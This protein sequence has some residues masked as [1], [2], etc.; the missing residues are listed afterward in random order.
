MNCENVQDLLIDGGEADASLRRDALEHLSECRDCRDA[1][2][3]VAALHGSRLQRIPPPTPGAMERALA[4]AV[5]GPASAGAARQKRRAPGAAGRAGFWSGVAVGGSL[6]AALAVAW[7][8]TAPSQQAA[9]GA[10]M[11]EVTLALNETRDINIAVDTPTALQ[12]AEIHVQLTG[13]I[14]LSGFEDQRELRWRT[15]LEAGNNQLTLP[16]IALGPRGGQVLVEVLHRDKR[17]K[18][19]VDVRS[20]TEA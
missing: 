15:N 16:V 4:A 5:G 12:D 8:V 9:P 10:A 2:Y 3:A 14:E 18:F 19:V 13:A 7:V 6:A 1:Q 20:A 11:P 17:R